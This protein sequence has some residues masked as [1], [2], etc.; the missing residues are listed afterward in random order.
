VHRNA[1]EDESVGFGGEMGDEVDGFRRCS[2]DSP[3]QRQ[4][5]GELELP[6]EPN[7]AVL[8]F[9][10]AGKAREVDDADEVTEHRRRIGR[11][12]RPDHLRAGRVVGVFEDESADVRG[13]SEEADEAVDGVDALLGLLGGH[14]DIA[15]GL[16]QVHRIAAT[17]VGTEPDHG[18]RVDSGHDRPLH[19]VDRPLRPSGRL[20]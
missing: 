13:H 17:L 9:E 20:T 6:D 12:Q 8:L 14:K 11:T 10:V 4:R 16:S 1:V 19:S 3:Q 2:A 5:R 7:A 18:D 15:P